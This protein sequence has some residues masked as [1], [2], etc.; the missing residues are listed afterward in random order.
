MATACRGN[1]AS[2]PLS[3][4][5]SLRVCAAPRRRTALTWMHDEH[6]VRVPMSPREPA[7][8]SSPAR[9]GPENQLDSPVLVAWSVACGSPPPA[10]LEPSSP[11]APASEPL[12]YSPGILGTRH[13]RHTLAPRRTL[14]L[15]EIDTA[16]CK[17]SPSSP[18]SSPRSSA[19]KANEPESPWRA[20]WTLTCETPP[21]RPCDIP[22]RAVPAIDINSRKHSLVEC[23][24]T[25]AATMAGLEAADTWA[26]RMQHG[27]TTGGTSGPAGFSTAHSPCSLRW[28]PRRARSPEHEHGA[29]AVAPSKRRRRADRVP[30]AER[31]A[32]RA[33]PASVTPAWAERHHPCH[34]PHGP[35]SA[36]WS[37]RAGLDGDLALATPSLRV[38]VDVV[39]T[40]PEKSLSSLNVASTPTFDAAMSDD[41]D[42]TPCDEVRAPH[43]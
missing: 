33:E 21:T 24:S 16:V 37:R 12:V 18:I 17:G 14:A 4:Q 34:Q 13:A 25:S 43:P 41:V 31:M 35:P 6:T 30:G 7:L 27:D 26:T 28:S 8:L 19:S 5:A 32:Q 20:A 9:A 3:Q 39:S 42:A 29:E 1:P 36:L 10:V 15:C 2:S 38:G 23:I 22:L 40:P 11:V